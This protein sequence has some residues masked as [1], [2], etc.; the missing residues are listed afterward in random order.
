MDLTGQST[1]QPLDGREYTDHNYFS[2]T[3]KKRYT[4]VYSN[5]TY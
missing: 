3:N 1:V 4:I 2:P 5:I